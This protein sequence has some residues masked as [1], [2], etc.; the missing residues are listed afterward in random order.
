MKFDI[1]NAGPSIRDEPLHDQ[2]D[3]ALIFN[4][5]FCLIVSIPLFILFCFV[6]K[7]VFRVYD[8]NLGNQNRYPLGGSSHFSNFLL[9]KLLEAFKMERFPGSNPR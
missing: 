2:P 1:T 3:K 9:G 8:A 6:R 7:H 4:L 5:Q